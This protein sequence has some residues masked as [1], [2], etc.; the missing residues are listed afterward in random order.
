[1]GSGSGGLAL[2]ADC[3]QKLAERR[4]RFPNNLVTNQN[5]P[6]ID[7][8]ITNA[9]NAK[10]TDHPH[11]I[12]V[13]KTFCGNSSCRQYTHLTSFL[14]MNHYDITDFLSLRKTPEKPIS[15]RNFA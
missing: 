9:S 13:K 14:E 12:F 8:G 4:Q 2:S 15:G 5:Q 6:P 1:M 11:A 7:L 10:Q 3:L